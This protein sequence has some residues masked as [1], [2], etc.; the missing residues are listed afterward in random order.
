MAMIRRDGGSF[1]FFF[2]EGSEHFGGGTAPSEREE[3]NGDFC[4]FF[5][6]FT[7]SRLLPSAM[8]F[9]A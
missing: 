4:P 2:L 1:L 9:I 6:R 8:T 3:K 7:F 5:L